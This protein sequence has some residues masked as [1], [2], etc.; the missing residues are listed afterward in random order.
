MEQSPPREADYCLATQE[1]NYFYG[2][3]VR[4]D[5]QIQQ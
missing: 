4:S 3:Y 2:I 5:E 1:I